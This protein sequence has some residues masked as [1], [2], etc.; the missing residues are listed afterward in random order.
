MHQLDALLVDK[1]YSVMSLSEHWLIA[2]ELQKILA[3]KLT[4]YTARSK[5]RGGGTL[6]LLNKKLKLETTNVLTINIEKCIELTCVLVKPYNLYVI[7]YVYRTPD[8]CFDTF[9]DALQSALQSIG[10]NRNIVVAGDFNVLFNSDQREAGYTCDLFE[11]YGF[12]KTIKE[13]TSGE[14]CLDN[15]FVSFIPESIE[16]ETVEMNMSDHRGTVVSFKLVTNKLNETV[17]ASFR[18]IT[19]RG[20]F[21]FYNIVETYRWDFIDST[22]ITINDKNLQFMELLSDAYA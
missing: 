9:L 2:K 7:G 3:Y 13:P 4:S 14:A 15:V 21:N 11:S 8:S 17:K 18:P 16:A 5:S 20:M 6:I 1:P 10:Y 12:Q 19:Q 22:N